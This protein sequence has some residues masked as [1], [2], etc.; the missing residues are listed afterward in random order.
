MKRAH[1]DIDGHAARLT[2]V[3]AV[4]LTWGD[5]RHEIDGVRLDTGSAFA[6]IGPASALGGRV[7]EDWYPGK[8]SGFGGTVVSMAFQ[9]ELNLG[10]PGWT[11]PV[12]HLT[13]DADHWW[14]GL[15]VLRHFDLLLRAAS[16]DAHR[17]CLEATEHLLLTR[18][19]TSP[20]HTP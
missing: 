11:L 16:E 7:P 12:V 6:L 3:K 10:P 15:P 2:L 8:V 13:E 4:V 19:P 5:D 18:S 1:A 9:A 14:V 17:P 20:A